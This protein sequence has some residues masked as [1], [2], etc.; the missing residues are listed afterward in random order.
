MKK[1]VK[2]ILQ[3]YNI[4]EKIQYGT[5]YRKMRSKAFRMHIKA[6]EDFYRSAIG[7]GHKLIFDIGANIGD[8]AF[9]F[10]KFSQKVICVEPDQ[11]NNRIL[12]ERFADKNVVIINKAV[13]EKIGQAKFHIEEEG[14]GYNTLSKKWV[15]I[16]EGNHEP[17]SS[18]ATKFTAELTVETITLDALIE[19]FGVPD[20]IKI[21][22]E[23]FELNVIRGLTIP[24]KLISFECNFPEFRSETIQI[25]EYLHLLDDKYIFNYADEY[26]FY[27]NEYV[28]AAEMI[29]IL[30]ATRHEFL[31]VYC[32]MS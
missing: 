14:S 7:T 21:D 26:H 11:K 12:S 9:I 29:A 17:H 3:H 24:I 2:K 22:V 15:G 30:K 23:G 32:K 10:K 31:E 27:L 4:L 25:I 16:L 1:L 6:Q 18:R 19:K 5:T 13:G 20:F 28:K 8:N